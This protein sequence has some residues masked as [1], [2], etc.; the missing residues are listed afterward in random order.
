MYRNSSNKVYS[1]KID[2]LLITIFLIWKSFLKYKQNHR[3]NTDLLI[4]FYFFFL[5]FFLFC[6]W[7]WMNHLVGSIKIVKSQKIKNFIAIKSINLIIRE[8]K[9][10][11]YKLKSPIYIYHQC[12]NVWLLIV[13]NLLACFFNSFKC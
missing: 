4:A 9:D 1:P 12:T 8:Q 11:I 7:M 3:P 5:F 10:I 13:S 2:K 6:Q